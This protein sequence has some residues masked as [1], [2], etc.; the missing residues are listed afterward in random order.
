MTTQ[1]FILAILDIQMPEMSGFELAELMRGVERTRSIPIIFLTA[2]SHSQNFE[3][4]GYEMGAVD[5][6]FKPVNP[7]ILKSKVQIFSKLAQKKIILAAKIIELQVAK[8]EAEQ[9]KKKAQEADRTKS[10]FLANM[11]HEIRTP[12]SALIGFTELMKSNHQSAEERDAYLDII[13][14][15]GK[16]LLA[17]INEILDLSKVEAGQ[18]D[19][20]FT[21]F[22]VREVV[23]D[24]VSLFDPIVK[25]ASVQL[26]VEYTE[27]VPNTIISDQM[28]LRQII[29]N[30][31]GNAIKFSPNGKVTVKVDYVYLDKYAEVH[32][33]IEDTGVGID[34]DKV[35]YLFQPFKQID[36]AISKTFG[37]TGLG[38]AVSKK[39]A[40]LL[41]GDINLIRSEVGKGSLFK[42][43][44]RDFSK[45][46]DQRTAA[47]GKRAAP[48]EKDFASL[49]NGI[50]VL[51]VDDLEDNQL[52][53]KVMLE[54]SKAKV[55]IASNG[56]EAVEKA[57]GSGKYDV[58]LM[59]SQ[60]PV[61]D[62]LDAIRILRSKGYT[63][64]IIS[65]TAN[66][67]VEERVRA[68]E[69]GSNEYLSKPIKW[70]QLMYTIY[71]LSSE[72]DA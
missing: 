10:N 51:L 43:N 14:R 9:A 17:L 66:A 50:S 55:D 19:T 53:I 26:E 45:I 28:K 27:S 5:F 24:I 65:L 33:N 44:L 71:Q 6:L 25:K 59:D 16:H 47:V 72:H 18:L 61:C 64:P 3:F 67:M 12:L 42:C 37:G 35:V 30:L 36:S 21:A 13:L 62:G 57:M 70:K 8:N 46:S 49:L 38:L 20:D 58:I 15:N 34:P 69:A 22:G 68:L 60:M 52:L 31:I 11:S 63:R 32:I 56:L 7:Y 29:T 54:R 23:N 1:D 39:L 40:H 48:G 2:G 4:K 41:K